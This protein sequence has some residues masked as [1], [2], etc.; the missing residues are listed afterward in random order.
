[1]SLHAQW[2]SLNKHTV[3]QNSGWGGGRIH[4]SVKSLTLGLLNEF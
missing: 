2:A 3:C 1:M 4:S